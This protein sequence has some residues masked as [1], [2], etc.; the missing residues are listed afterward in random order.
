MVSY[1]H[2]DVEEY[3]ESA[4]QSP[5]TS[6]FALRVGNSTGYL[7]SEIGE[8]LRLRGG[9]EPSRVAMA[10]SIRNFKLNAGSKGA[11]ATSKKA[12]VEENIAQENVVD[13]NTFFRFGD[14]VAELRNR[15]YYFYAEDLDN[16]PEGP[17][18]LGQSVNNVYQRPERPLPFNLNIT[19]VSKLVRNESL[20]IIGAELATRGFHL[21]HYD[22]TMLQSP[23]EQAMLPAFGSYVQDVRL[24]RGGV[25]RCL[26][27]LTPH[28]PNLK[29]VDVQLHDHPQYRRIAVN[30][31]F[32]SDVSAQDVEDQL[33]FDDKFLM[34]KLLDVDDGVKK[35]RSD[36][37]KAKETHPELFVQGREWKV[38]FIIRAYLRE[39]KDDDDDDEEVDMRWRF[40]VTFEADSG[41]VAE[42]ARL[43]TDA[44]LGTVGDYL[45]RRWRPRVDKT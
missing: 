3:D 23:V 27:A 33:D 10:S 40:K 19:L 5:R 30:H 44:I 41:R 4:G 11:L 36:Y 38:R 8:G 29:T 14:L 7:S 16:I 9:V 37:N 22:A 26:R 2:Y 24:S 15:V 31:D 18:T 28:A 20:P 13:E 42:V 1:R 21:T 34:Q 43:P 39:T 12:I 17:I 35:I 6:V 25:L 32:P 45:S